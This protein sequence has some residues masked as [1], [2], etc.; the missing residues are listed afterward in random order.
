MPR[1]NM[2]AHITACYRIGGLQGLLRVPCWFWHSVEA[3]VPRRLFGHFSKF[4]A[5]SRGASSHMLSQLN[6]CDSRVGGP[7]SLKQKTEGSRAPTCVLINNWP[8]VR[9][10]CHS[11]YH[12]LHFRGLKGPRH[13]AP[14]AE[15]LILN[16]ESCTG[17]LLSFP[18]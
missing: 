10:P 12:A 3:V 11:S 9:K 6:S 13:G 18:D 17:R 15:R 4:W 7:S 2:E 14:N 8:R 1:G 5:P 16:P